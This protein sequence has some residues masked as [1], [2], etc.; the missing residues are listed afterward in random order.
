MNERPEGERPGTP[1]GPDPITCE[2]AVERVYEYLDGELDAVSTEQVRRHIE[3]CKRCYPHFNFE[4]IFLDHIRSS[5]L[6]ASCSE[7]LE[8]RILRVLREAQ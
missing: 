1:G 5:A 3:M 6:K 7:E 4:R 2:Q 8:E